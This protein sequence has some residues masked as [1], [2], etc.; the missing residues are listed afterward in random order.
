MSMQAPTPPRIGRIW[1]PAPREEVEVTAAM[2]AERNTVHS[3]RMLSECRVRPEIAYPMAWTMMSDAIMSL[4][5]K[6]ICSDSQTR[7]ALLY[8]LYCV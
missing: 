5:A 3:R 2:D 6:T 8:S 1:K 4:I 7:P